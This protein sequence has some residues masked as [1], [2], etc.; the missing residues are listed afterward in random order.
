[1]AV[2]SS[3]TSPYKWYI[4]HR[5][6][7]TSVYLLAI[8]LTVTVLVLHDFQP[9]FYLIPAMMT[10]GL[11]RL[12][13][14]QTNHVLS[15]LAL[16]LVGLAC[17]SFLASAVRT[18]QQRSLQLL[19]NYEQFKNISSLNSKIEKQSLFPPVFNIFFVETNMNRGKQI[20][21]VKTVFDSSIERVFIIYYK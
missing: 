18:R 16:F 10:I 6:H 20:K 7:V 12:A 11:V 19:Y 3:K 14:D 5:N 15:A 21:L 17:A 2:A 9:V 4:F 8:Y 13:W 1:M